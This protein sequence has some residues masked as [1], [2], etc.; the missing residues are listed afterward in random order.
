MNANP[1][2]DVQFFLRK[3]A[4][5]CDIPLERQ[6]NFVQLHCPGCELPGPIITSDSEILE[7]TTF[8]WL[9]S[10]NDGRADIGLIPANG[11]TN[12]IAVNRSMQG[13]ILSSTI[14]FRISPASS[15][16]YTIQSLAQA[17]PPVNLNRL[18]VEFLVPFS[19]ANNFDLEVRSITLL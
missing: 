5:Q 6:N 16:T 9:D 10:N 18:Y 2:Y 11:N 13:D 7:R 17:N 14:N 8:G 15:P 1:S 3:G 4:G 19:E 12:G